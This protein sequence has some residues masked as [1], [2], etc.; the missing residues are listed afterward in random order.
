MKALLKFAGR[1][2]VMVAACA[3]LASAAIAGTLTVT[4]P[5]N[6]AFVGSS[7]T[8][9]FR[10]A[11]GV[12]E[13]TVRA[14]I[15]SKSTGASTTLTTQVTPDEN[16]D[17]NGSLQWSP[18]TSFPEGDYTIHVTAT[19]P[20][21]TYKPTTIIVTLDRL[22]P[23]LFEYSPINNS[24]INGP[25]NITA[26][27]DEP[28]IDTWRVTVNDADLPNNTGSTP[29]V[30]VLWD[31]ENIE[32]D[33]EQTVKILVK[34][35]A[36]NESTQTITVTLDRAAPVVN[37]VYPRVNQ[38]IIPGSIVTV[39]VLIQ[40][41]SSTSVDPVAV[42]AEIQDMG[43]NVIRRV[44]RLTYEEVNST[45]ARWVGRWRAVTTG[46]VEK[47]KLVVNVVDRAGNVAATQTVPL[48]FGR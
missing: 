5:A 27:I 1:G 14:V 7:T 42:V 47:F 11:G 41:I 26:L 21:N 23:R 3:T 35:L 6:G 34:D 39:L 17:A 37:V 20:G 25:I 33:G 38:A 48:H 32:L 16:G 9:T 44:S 15:T 24:F 36:R 45:T 8:I 22:D 13:V 19:E 10:I 2:V 30:N 18:S 28:N 31:P 29:S 12:V 46:G 43:G 40:D 4:A